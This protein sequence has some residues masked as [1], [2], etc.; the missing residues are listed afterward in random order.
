MDL[1]QTKNPKNENPLRKIANDI[2]KTQTKEENKNNVENI[3][4]ENND[5]NIPINLPTALI[6]DKGSGK[7][8]LIKAIINASISNKIFNN[9]YFIYSSTT[10][11]SVLPS[12]V[13]KVDV[14]ECEQ[15][16]SMLFETKSIFNSYYKFFKSLD[17][18]KLNNLY[19]SGK[20][21]DADISKNL[22]NNIIKYNKTIINSNALPTIKIDKIFH[23]GE[24]ILDV[25]SKPFNIGTVRING[26]RYNDRDAIIIDDIAIAS[27]MLFISMKDNDFYEYLTLTRHMRLF[28]LLSGQQIEQIPKSIRREIMCWILSKNTN[29]ELLIGVLQK[30]ALKRII[31]EQDKLDK[32]EFVIYNVPD[33]SINI[34]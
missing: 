15:F 32:Y 12:E 6:G 3:V 24:K 19:E 20:L 14:N 22:D 30:S 33:G 27:K 7:T 5:T 11:D 29:I 4:I 18:K 28:V 8:T 9:I 25:F 1:L 13:I 26:L 21:T 31:Q 17:F 2:V 34:L 16:L 10:Y 23:T